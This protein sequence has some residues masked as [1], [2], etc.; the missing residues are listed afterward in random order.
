VDGSVVF[1]LAHLGRP[2]E[3]SKLLAALRLNGHVFVQSATMLPQAMLK[4]TYDVCKVAHALPREVRQRFSREDGRDP[5]IVDLDGV[6]SFDPDAEAEQSA[7]ASAVATTD[8]YKLQSAAGGV[9]SRLSYSAQEEAY[10]PGTE[11]TAEY[12][13]NP[14]LVLTRTSHYVSL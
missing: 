11:A 8:F 14:H 6:E 12:G 1:D 4:E 9:R 2:A 7:A 13:A 3:L 5:S 10:E